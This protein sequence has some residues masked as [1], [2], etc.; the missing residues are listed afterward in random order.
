[1]RRLNP[2]PV[3]IL[4]KQTGS[5]ASPPFNYRT[6][7]Y[8]SKRTA[9]R[10]DLMSATFRGP[11]GGARGLVMRHK[12]FS[13]TGKGEDR[14]GLTAGEVLKRASISTSLFTT[15]HN[16]ERIPVICLGSPSTKSLILFATMSRVT[17][18][19][20]Y[21]PSKYELPGVQVSYLIVP[22]LPGREP[23][24]RL[25]GWPGDL[26]ARQHD[27]LYASRPA[28]LLRPKWCGFYHV[29]VKVHKKHLWQHQQNAK[30]VP[31]NLEKS[32]QPR[33]GNMEAVWVRGVSS[34]P[35]ASSDRWSC[36]TTSIYSSYR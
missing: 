12:H 14:S 18:V 11:M 27:D 21:C 15:P 4:E 32:S 23:V 20:E 9:L 16:V 22:A 33:D 7:F 34:P 29:R 2:S 10:T 26:V 8:L 13:I 28:I 6:R 36:C 17:S 30:W 3:V 35:A 25:W 31:S 1:M 5:K 24:G 19:V